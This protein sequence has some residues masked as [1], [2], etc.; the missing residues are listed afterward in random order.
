MGEAGVAVVAVGFAAALGRVELV[1]SRFDNLGNI[2]FRGRGSQ[3]I[4]AA[5]AA[6]A[7]H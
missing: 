6:Q 1:F 5:R 7:L 4:T 2:D 3:N